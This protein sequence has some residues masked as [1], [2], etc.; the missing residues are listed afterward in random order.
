MSGLTVTIENADN[1]QDAIAKAVVHGQRFYGAAVDLRIVMEA[2]GT[3]IEVQRHD[4]TVVSAGYDVTF[5]IHGDT[6]D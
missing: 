6:D 4:G 3:G 1:L 5:T 2:A